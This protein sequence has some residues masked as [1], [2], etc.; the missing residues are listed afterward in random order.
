MVGGLVFGSPI[1]LPPS[2]PTVVGLNPG[3]AY[4][5][6]KRW[7]PARYVDL[8]RRLRDE[9]GAEIVLFGAASERELAE[10]IAAGIG[11]G[12]R[13]TAGQTTL[14]EFVKLVAGCHLFVTND[15]GTMHVAAAMGVP[16]LAIFGATDE[17]ATAPLGPRV[18]L[19]KK[20]VPCS[21][22]LLRHC[23][24]DHRCMRE[25]PVSEVFETACQILNAVRPSSSTVTAR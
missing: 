13:S 25:I 8:G 5:T 3:A 23:P 18:H 12:A 11:A 19:I 17:R 15:T 21:P 4:G 20:A 22:C 24:V 9:R 10:Q 6:A 1:P 16:V 14:A 7:L 2:P